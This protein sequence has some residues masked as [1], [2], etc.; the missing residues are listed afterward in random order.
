MNDHRS[1]RR[2]PGS[3]A[4]PTGD[5]PDSSANRAQHQE[6]TGFW[7]PLWE[8]DDDP[9][10]GRRRAGANGAQGSNGA[11]H[12]RPNGNGANGGSHRMPERDPRGAHHAAPP[13]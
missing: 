2:G 9:N 12:A 6:R 3:P 5:D 11:H 7:S 13:P 8:D 10:A 1:H 4:W